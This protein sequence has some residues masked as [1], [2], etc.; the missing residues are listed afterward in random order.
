MTLE[1]GSALLP[2]GDDLMQVSQHPDE[3][4]VLDIGYTCCGHSWG[5]V[6][7]RGQGKLGEAIL[8][9]GSREREQPGNLGGRVSPLMQGAELG[10]ID[11]DTVHRRPPEQE[12]IHDVHL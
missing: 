5:S 1:G 4:I 11:N 3:D 8:Y 6:T 7:R 10:I 12:C 9:G 2:P